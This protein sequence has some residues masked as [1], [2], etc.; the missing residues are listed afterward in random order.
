MQRAG[1]AVDRAARATAPTGAGRPLPTASGAPALGAG[2]DRSELLER[3]LPG[4]VE[5]GEQELEVGREALTIH[6]DRGPAR[7]AYLHPRWKRGEYPRSAQL[8]ALASGEGARVDHA[9]RPRAS[10]SCPSERRLRERSRSSTGVP[11]SARRRTSRQDRPSLTSAGMP[12][13]TAVAISTACRM[14]P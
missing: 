2:A 12:I 11:C 3:L 6:D 14:I 9:R 13:M 5:H 4:A 7:E 8:R 10:I 1:G